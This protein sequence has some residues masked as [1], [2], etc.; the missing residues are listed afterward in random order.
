M[1]DGRFVL[2]LM[3]PVSISQC[4]SGRRT[5]RTIRSRRPTPSM[6]LPRD[7]LRDPEAGSLRWAVGGVGA[8]VETAAQQ[9]RRGSPTK[10]FN[11]RSECERPWSCSDSTTVEQRSRGDTLPRNGSERVGRVVG[12]DL[13]RPRRRQDQ[14]EEEA[15]GVLSQVRLSGPNACWQLDATEYVFTAGRKCTIFQLIDDTPDSRSPPTSP[16]VRP[17]MSRYIN[18]HRCL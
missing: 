1:F 14:A 12:A 17:R 4:S 16:G 3:I 15:V 5:S 9:P 6:D 7:L 8:T 10:W 18:C 13:T 11:W 2:T